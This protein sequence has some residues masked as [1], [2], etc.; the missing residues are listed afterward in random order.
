MEK[1]VEKPKTNQS[2]TD[3]MTNIEKWNSVLSKIKKH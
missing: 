1:P 2:F 3:N